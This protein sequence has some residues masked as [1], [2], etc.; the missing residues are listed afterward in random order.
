[1]IR[2]L[3][4]ILLDNLARTVTEDRRG[5]MDCCYLLM[6]HLQYFEEYYKEVEA[7]WLEIKTFLLELL[8]SCPVSRRQPIELVLISVYYIK[9][10]RNDKDI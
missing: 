5:F 8:S 6:C 2:L 9:P 1:M 3:A 10:F 7:E 4:D